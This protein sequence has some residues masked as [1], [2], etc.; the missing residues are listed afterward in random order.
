[1]IIYFLLFISFSYA[2]IKVL[3][4]FTSALVIPLL[5]F[6]QRLSKKTIDIVICKIIIGVATINNPL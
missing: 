1:M 2:S 5:F 6:I 4:S 3:I